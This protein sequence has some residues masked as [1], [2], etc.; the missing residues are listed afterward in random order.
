MG[1]FSNKKQ[2]YLENVPILATSDHQNFSSELRNDNRSPKTHAQN[3]SL[4]DV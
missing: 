4:W 1:S 2:K 3:K